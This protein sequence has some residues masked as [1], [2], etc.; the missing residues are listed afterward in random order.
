M[1]IPDGFIAPQ[2][3]LPLYA[4]SAGAWGYGLRRLRRELGSETLPL[5]AVMTSLAFLLSTVA[6]PLPGGTTVH[7]TGIGMLAV[8]FGVWT[9]FIALSMVFAMQALLFGVGGVTAL[10]LNALA[11]GLV[12]S[13]AAC[14]VFRA[15]RSRAETAGLFA[16]GALPVL[17]SALLIALAL[18]A[19]PHIASRAD[20]T[21][22]FFPYGL[23]ITVP[24]V[25]LPHLVV[26][27]AEGV[28]TVAVYRFVTRLRGLNTR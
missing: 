15:L 16:A 5:L 25:L 24:A 1:H 8:L 19:Q 13:L 11:M 6:L 23:A 4:V 2:M 26:A 27:A 22:L 28:L 9:S 7:A 3:Y 18:G 14:M 20:G 12:G 17:A 10:P 21:P